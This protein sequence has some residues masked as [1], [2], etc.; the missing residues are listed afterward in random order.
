MESQVGCNLKILRS[1]SWAGSEG[2]R[3]LFPCMRFR[4][5]LRPQF[6]SIL[7]LNQSKSIQNQTL[8]RSVK[9]KILISLILN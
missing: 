5:C 3:T 2:S 1:F 7:R 8:R 4:G 6:Q 9:N